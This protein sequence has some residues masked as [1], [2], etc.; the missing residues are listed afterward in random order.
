M[1]TSVFK[2]VIIFS[3]LFSMKCFADLQGYNIAPCRFWMS[4]QQGGYV[5]QNIPATILVPKAESFAAALREQQSRIT[6]LEKK[7]AEIAASCQ[8]P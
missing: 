6:E 1:K 7:V 3:Y 5:C 8:K 2:F 4:N